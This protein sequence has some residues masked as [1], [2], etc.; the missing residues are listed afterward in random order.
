MLQIGLSDLQVDGGLAQC[1]VLRLDDLTGS[2]FVGGVQ[3]GS[4]ASLT[5]NAIIDAA[6][7]APTD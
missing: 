4:F 6:T 3:A 2:V 5:I 1:L 7:S